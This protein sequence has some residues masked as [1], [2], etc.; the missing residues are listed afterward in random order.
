MRKIGFVVLVMG[1]FLAS[2]IGA[3]P[4]DSVT[5]GDHL[6]EL[7]SMNEFDGEFYV[8]TYKVTSGSSPALS[9]WILNLCIDFYDHSSEPTVKQHYDEADP[10]TGAFGTKFDDEYVDG[11]MREVKIYMTKATIAVETDLNV[12]TK[13]GHSQVYTGSILAPSC[14]EVPEPTT[15]ALVAAGVLGMTARRRRIL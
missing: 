11:E 3:T 4:I 6:I 7:I 8:W 14:D 15:M 12:T 5:L 9:H 13:A 2:G 10:T 1:L